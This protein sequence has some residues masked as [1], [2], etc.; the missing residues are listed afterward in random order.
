M[1]PRSKLW[2]KRIAIA[3]AALTVAVLVA[4]HYCLRALDE[5]ILEV[6]GPG[7]S[8]G[9][10]DLGRR[11]IVL[12]EVRMPMPKGWIKG[13]K[14]D[15]AASARSVR[16]R[17]ELRSLIGGRARIRKLAVDHGVIVLRRAGDGRLR[18]L[19]GITEKSNEHHPAQLD[20]ISF[21]DSV[22]DIYD[23]TVTQPPHYMHL[24][25]VHG[26]IDHLNPPALDQR[27]VIDL[28]GVVVGAQQRGEVQLKGWIEFHSRDSQ[29]DIRLKGVDLDTV[30]PYLQSKN[31][32]GVQHGLLNLEMTSTVREHQLRAPGTMQLSQLHFTPDKEGSGRFLGVPRAAVLNFMEKRRDPVQLDFVVEGDLGNPKFSLNEDFTTRAGVALAKVMGVSV[33]GVVE[34]VGA[35]GGLGIKAVTGVGRLFG[36][37]KKDDKPADEAAS[38]KK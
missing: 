23:E 11:E 28:Q 31:D 9:S 24:E 17:P 19:P 7:S 4:A 15:E 18:L 37:G 1:T 3:A 26:T 20:R 2:F 38:K 29:L 8:V 22:L 25:Q 14:V 32:H 34:G 30:Q 6:L 13:A 21:T 12:H 33:E 35:V 10:T 5:E 36:A 27:S 16:I